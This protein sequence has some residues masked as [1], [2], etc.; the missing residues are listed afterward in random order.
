[1]DGSY[2]GGT[3]VSWARSDVTEMVIVS[4]L[5]DL[6][7]GLGGSAESIEDL[8]D[9][10]TFLHGDDSKLIFFIDPDEESLVVVVVDS[11]S[12]RPFSLETSRL[13]VF[14][15]TLEEE[16][17]GDELLL[18]RISHLSERVVLTS[19]IS[20]ELS[21]CRCNE[22]LNFESLLSGN[23][24]TKRIGSEVSCDSNSGRVD[25]LVLVGWECWAVKLVVIHGRNVLVSWLMTVI[26]FDDL[27]EEWGKGVVGI[28]G[29]SVDAD[30]RVGPFGSREDSLS[31]SETELI[32][33]VF[34]LLPE[35]SG[36]KLLKKRSS[37]GW[38]VWITLDIFWCFQMRTHESSIEFSLGE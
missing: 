22:G 5:G 7:D 6:L 21:E 12:F 26:G 32:S 34:A 35:I 27:V 16:V 8:F 29:S 3:E 28:V 2:H 17:I 38:E 37:S 23:S 19:K 4:E 9:T 36:E 11:S 33:S 13:E 18:L 30:T 15:A 1:M 10:S 24:S 14:V 31:E 25:H 20:F